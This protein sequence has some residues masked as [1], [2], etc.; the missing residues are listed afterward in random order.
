[1]TFTDGRSESVASVLGVADVLVFELSGE[2]ARLRGGSGRGAGWAGVVELNLSDEPNVQ[3]LLSGGG[4]VRLSERAPVRIVGPYWSPN[5]ALARTGDHVVVIG[6]S[7]PIR[8]S[9]AELTRRAAEAVAAIGDVPPSKLLADEL[10]VVHAVRQL[11]D[12]APRT[13]AETATHVADVASDALACEIGA[14]LLLQDGQTKV[15]GG[16]PAWAEL[17][18]DE[19]SRAALHD[20]ARRAVEGPV[21]EQDLAAAGVSGLRIVSCYALGIGRSEPLGAL[22]VGHTDARPRG[23]T[24]LC[25]RVGRALADAS[26]PALRQAMALEDLAAQRDRFAQ[27][28]RTDPLTG[29]GN[30]T[31]WDVMLAI[32]QARWE[33]HHRSLVLLSIDLDNLKAT[34]DR[35]GHTVG[36]ELLI[37]AANVLRG[38]LRGGD[39]IARVGGDEFAAILPEADAS[40]AEAVQRRV[41]AASA[42][43][44]GSRDELSLS[45]SIG[46]AAP[47]AGERLLDA[48][49][50]A[51]AAMY[52]AKRG[53]IAFAG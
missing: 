52:E 49:G 31:S 38:A 50:R 45:I 44:R 18:D 14:V 4:V 41:R 17:A 28:A 7:E 22:I 24:Q 26:E 51:D 19:A 13:V 2:Q 47:V 3:A 32:E 20:L 15:H 37:A 53:G 12:H 48:Y 10:E 27:E 35:F 16:G 21:V 5:A 29:L 42:A 43:W 33:R 11:T 9:T 30:R 46:W 25:Q 36:D 6:S 1:M 34:N 40:S 39:V 23:F 8:A